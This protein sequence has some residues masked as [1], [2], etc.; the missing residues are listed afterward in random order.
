MQHS[1]TL[2]TGE[3]HVSVDKF[4]RDILNNMEI[5]L[6]RDGMFLVS[7]FKEYNLPI[8]ELILLPPK[9]QRWGTCFCRD[10]KVHIYKHD[11]NTLLHEYA[12]A[13]VEEKYGAN[14][15]HDSLFGQTL[16]FIIERWWNKHI[17]KVGQ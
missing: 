5:D 13:F 9:R 10:K 17:R 11:V 2:G 1:Y 14:H 3:S 12:H 4:K 16:D 8:Y 6:L 7:L 15:G